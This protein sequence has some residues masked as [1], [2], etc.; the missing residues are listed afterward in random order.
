MQVFQ[1]GAHC[2]S[3]SVSNGNPRCE[4][5]ADLYTYLPVAAGWLRLAGCAR[6]Q[7]GTGT[8]IYRACVGWVVVT[9]SA[10]NSKWY[11]GRCCK[12]CETLLLPR[13]C[14]RA[15]PGEDGECKGERVRARGYTCPWAGPAQP[16]FWFPRFCQFPGAVHPADPACWDSTRERPHVPAVRG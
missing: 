6:Q 16:F 14:C 5:I 10:R 7:L 3:C 11:S 12:C 2:A 15:F 8:R 9:N 1:L 4:T 13:R